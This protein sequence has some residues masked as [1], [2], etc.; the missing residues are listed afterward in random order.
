MFC[1]KCRGEFR[2]GL[3]WCAGCD[4]SLVSHQPDDDPF[5][6]KDAMAVLLEGKELESLVTANQELLLQLQR[7]LAANRIATVIST[8]S[9]D[10]RAMGRFMLLCLNSDIE[11]A[12]SFFGEEWEQSVAAE[13]LKEAVLDSE[14]CPACTS[15]VPATEEECPEC[16]LFV[17]RLEE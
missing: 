17:G 5:S 11:Q 15:P 3:E 10:H 16:G 8:E 7:K 13:G 2:P 1:P 6:S 4:V 14:N 9:E 12:R